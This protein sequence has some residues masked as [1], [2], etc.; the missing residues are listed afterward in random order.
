MS[1]FSDL[2]LEYSELLRDIQTF[3]ARKEEIKKELEQT[4]T[5]TGYPVSDY[6]FIAQFK[7]GRKT[8]NYEKAL[9]DIGYLDNNPEVVNE[10]TKVRYTTSWAKVAKVAELDSE[11]LKSYVTQ[12][13]STFIITEQV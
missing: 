8:T 5:E 2:F 11:Y 10:F 6:G 4:V 7:E 13:E 3:T 9:N 1:N 12:Q